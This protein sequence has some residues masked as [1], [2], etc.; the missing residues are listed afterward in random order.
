M[1]ALHC[2]AVHRQHALW[3]AFLNGCSAAC[4]SKDSELAH[5]I[6]TSLH[7]VHCGHTLTSLPLHA[8][9]PPPPPHPHLTTVFDMH[10]PDC[11]WQQTRWTQRETSS[12]RASCATT[13]STMKL[14]LQ[15]SLPRS[16]H[17]PPSSLVPVNAP[18]V[19]SARRL[20]TFAVLQ[21]MIMQ[22]LLAI[23]VCIAKQLCTCMSRIASYGCP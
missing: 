15:E 9:L 16:V 2:T 8:P 6:A 13:G 3:L 12:G 1:A 22:L 5:I 4:V 7:C 20:A 10:G 21:L 11:R 19:C 23:V 18:L 17:H 14:P